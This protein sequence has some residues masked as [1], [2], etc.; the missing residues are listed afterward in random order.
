MPTY[1]WQCNTGHQWEAW[2][3]IHDETIPRCDCE[4]TVQKVLTPPR[5]YG[6]G[7][8][9]AFTRQTDATERTWDR[10]R[11][12]YKRL[13]ANGM[14]PPHVDGAAKLETLADNDLEVN[15]GLR[16]GKIE[17]R[18]VKEAITMAKE[19]GW[20]PTSVS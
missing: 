9:G 15:T 5:L 3:S 11:P 16:Y 17:E 8:R 10:D 4:G 18:P 19:S 6:V 12:A 14:Q 13:R 2:Q 1:R 20:T 7:D